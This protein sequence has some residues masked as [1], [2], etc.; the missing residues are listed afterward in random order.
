MPIKLQLRF[1]ILLVAIA[2]GGR[3][4]AFSRVVSAEG[5][6]TT[7]LKKASE[8]PHT[9][10]KLVSGQV[11]P[12]SG[13]QLTKWNGSGMPAAGMQRLTGRGLH[14]GATNAYPFLLVKEYLSFIYPSHHF[15]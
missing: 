9:E 1:I 13:C 8:S 15:W 2:A 4:A 7:L 10:L 14:K 3:Q 6:Q 12:V 5:V 11:S